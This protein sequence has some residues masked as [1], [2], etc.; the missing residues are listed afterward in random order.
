[1]Q[2][3]VCQAPGLVSVQARKVSILLPYMP[4]AFDWATLI[5]HHVPYYSHL[6]DWRALQ[7]QGLSLAHLSSPLIRSVPGREWTLHE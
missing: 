5:A 1:M 7:G 4:V 6:L 3:P 2:D